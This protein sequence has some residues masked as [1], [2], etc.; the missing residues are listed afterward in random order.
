MWTPETS[1]LDLHTY[2]LLSGVIA[3]VSE[4]VDIFNIDDNFIIPVVGGGLLYGL[5]KLCQV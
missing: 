5:V 2:A 4:F 3:S 1:I